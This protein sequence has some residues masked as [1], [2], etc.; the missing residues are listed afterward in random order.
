MI[1]EQV[2]VDE[3]IRQKNRAWTN[4]SIEEKVNCLSKVL[5]CWT[6]NLINLGNLKSGVRDSDLFEIP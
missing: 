5:F 4:Q 2:D 3:E 6:S 1:E